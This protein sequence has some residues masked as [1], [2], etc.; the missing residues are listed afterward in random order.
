MKYYLTPLGAM[1]VGHK[2]N[3]EIL[4][5]KDIFKICRKGEK[6]F[7]IVKEQGIYKPTEQQY[8]VALTKDMYYITKLED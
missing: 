4:I 5:E 1:M 6:C 3:D 7:S 2:P 8:Y